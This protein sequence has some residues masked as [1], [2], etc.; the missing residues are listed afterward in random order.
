MI[1]Q[2]FLFPPLSM[3]DLKLFFQWLEAMNDFVVASSTVI[4]IEC[5]KETNVSERRIVFFSFI[6]G[7]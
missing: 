6:V 2:S 5:P 4:S 3:A 7:A 1:S